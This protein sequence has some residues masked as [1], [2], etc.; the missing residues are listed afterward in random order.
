MEIL[1]LRAALSEQSLNALVSRHLPGEI[2]IEELRFLITEE[3]L[4]IKG[5]YPLLVTVSFETL[6]E[7]TVRG[8]KVLARLSRL[9]TLGM[10]MGVLKSL[11]MGAIASTAK[12]EEWLGVDRDTIEVDVERLLA[13]E[14]V[15]ARLNLTGIRCEA[16]VLLIEA[17][18]LPGA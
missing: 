17:G 16:G 10:P 9:R 7:L 1:A 8:G 18:K 14:G 13:R 12:T 11:V 2:P 6:W 5:E 4:V 15:P 3:G